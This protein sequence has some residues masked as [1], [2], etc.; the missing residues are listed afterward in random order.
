MMRVTDVD[1]ESFFIHPHQLDVIRVTPIEE[2]EFQGSSRFR[3]RA[4]EGEVSRVSI[5]IDGTEATRVINVL[6]D[7]F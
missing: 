5:V 7:D 4:Y 1:G 2:N 6:G 3:F